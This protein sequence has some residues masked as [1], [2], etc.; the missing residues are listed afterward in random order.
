MDRVTATEKNGV[1]AQNFVGYEYNINSPEIDNLQKNNGFYLVPSKNVPERPTVFDKTHCLRK[2]TQ[3]GKVEWKTFRF[4]DMED[5]DVTREGF[6]YALL[7]DENTRSWISTEILQDGILSLNG[8][9]NA[10]QELEAYTKGT[11]DFEITESQNIHKF[12]IPYVEASGVTRGMMSKESYNNLK[13]KSNNEL[14]QGK[15][16]IGDE[17]DKMKEVTISGGFQVDETGATTITKLGEDGTFVFNVVENS[18]NLPVRSSDK[19]KA[20]RRDIV[21]F[22]M[23]VP[24]ITNIPGGKD[25]LF[26]V[27][28]V[29]NSQDGNSINIR[30]FSRESSGYSTSLPIH[31]GD[32]NTKEVSFTSVTSNVTQTKTSDDG[33]VFVRSGPNYTIEIENHKGI[34]LSSLYDGSFVSYVGLS[35]KIDNYSHNL[36]FLTEEAGNQNEYLGFR[37]FSNDDKS[38]MYFANFLDLNNVGR[39]LCTM[40]EGNVTQFGNIL[41][42]TNIDTCLIVSSTAVSSQGTSYITTNP[43]ISPG[44][45]GQFPGYKS[46]WNLPNLNRI[47]PVFAV[48]VCLTLGQ[49]TMYTY[50][51]NYDAI[52]SLDNSFQLVHFDGNTKSYNDS[53]PKVISSVSPRWPQVDSNF[54]FGQYNAKQYNKYINY[55]ISGI[56]AYTTNQFVQAV[57]LRYVQNNKNVPSYN[58]FMLGS[59][60]MSFYEI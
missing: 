38:T 54:E 12:T 6:E 47:R 56:V 21:T 14:S 40:N 13:D 41:G 25:L 34:T 59:S 53:N 19:F 37:A 9:L 2:A 57:G 42:P 30:T 50:K 3:D 44:N 24:G 51:E 43:G 45:L 33:K 5:V 7:Y 48:T 27:P 31:I 22:D 15:I 1:V 46:G 18:L 39:L 55:K 4:S 58:F 26:I 29:T 49:T 35:K 10:F 52:Q 17:N 8:V 11:T 20:I 16:L 32:K 28:D 23:Q 60:T 36:T